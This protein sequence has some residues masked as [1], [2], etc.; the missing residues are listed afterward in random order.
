M[1]RRL[2][3]A[4]VEPFYGGSHAAFVDGWI[5]RSHHEWQVVSLPA[6]AWKWRMR[7][8]GLTLGQRLARLQPQPDAVVVSGL[9]DAMHLRQS[10][11]PALQRCA[12]LIYWH[13]NQF[14]YPRPP[15]K[16]LDRGFAV[17][18]LASL[19]AADAHAFNSRSHRDAFIAA[20]RAHGSQLP[21]EAQFSASRGWLRRVS[22]L[23]PGVDFEG[24]PAPGNRPVGTP[25]RVVWNHR[26]EED[27]RPSAFAHTMSKLARKGHE[28]RLILLGPVNQVQPQPLIQLRSELSNQIERDQS[29]RTRREYL[30]WLTRSDI[31]VTTAAQ[32]NFGY[33]VIEAMAAG[34][35]PLMPR[36]LSYP[37]LVPASLHTELLYDTDRE[38]A[39][40]LA[41]WLRQ[42]ERIVSLRARVMRTARRHDWMHRV[43]A[44]DAWVEQTVRTVRQTRKD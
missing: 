10:A 30:Q 7:L 6:Q 29:A 36:R 35:V 32:E 34:A 11:G 4:F 26:W 28:F 9:L 1:P 15:G 19:L 12:W 24:F 40:R 25:P 22:V 16:P 5:A 23:P 3:V 42:P 14:D 31:A 2:R 41:A 21:R 8:A 27:K 17:A 44:L 20:W 37:Q 18:H 33:A 38:L 39:S 13:E 43:A